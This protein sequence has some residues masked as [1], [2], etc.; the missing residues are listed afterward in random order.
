MVGTRYP[1]PAAPRDPGSMNWERLG[2][3]CTGSATPA[4]Q[5]HR[6]G[7]FEL[8]PLAPSASVG[9]RWIHGLFR[10]LLTVLA[11]VWM[12]MGSLLRPGIMARDQLAPPFWLKTAQTS[13]VNV[14]SFPPYPHTPVQWLPVRGRCSGYRRKRMAI[15]GRPHGTLCTPGRQHGRVLASGRNHIGAEGTAPLAPA[16]RSGPR[17]ASHLGVP[18]ALDG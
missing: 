13:G 16:L 14:H 10:V 8:A 11:T 18:F 7:P 17:P 5:L 15:F 4:T 6:F 3:R 2:S 1:V 12:R 9:I